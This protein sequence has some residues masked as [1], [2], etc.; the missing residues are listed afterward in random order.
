MQAIDAQVE[1]L[2]NGL[3]KAFGSLW[4]SARGAVTFSQRMAQQ[5]EAVAK[6]MG[7]QVQAGVREGH[8][9]AFFRIVSSIAPAYNR[10]QQSMY[11]PQI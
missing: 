3:T 5:M 1:Q 6:E 8:R 11:S 4:G 9:S 7:T 10:S 2:S